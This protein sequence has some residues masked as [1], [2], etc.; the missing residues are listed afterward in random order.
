[1]RSRHLCGRNGG[2]CGDETTLT[3]STAN[4]AHAEVCDGIDND[5]DGKLDAADAADLLA[6]DLQNCEKQSRSMR[7]VPPSQP[8][9]V[10]EAIGLR[11]EPSC[12]R[13]TTPSMK[14]ARKFDATVSITIAMPAWMKISP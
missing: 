10:R 7:R 9:C 5:C 11:A 8:L 2:V 4:L 13:I 6:N 14:R 12:T 3:C 1:M